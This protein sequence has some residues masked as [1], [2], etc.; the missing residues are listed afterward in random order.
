M[1]DKKNYQ[2]KAHKML[3]E[4]FESISMLDKRA[5]E[6]SG[7]VREGLKDTIE[8]LKRES[9]ELKG[10]FA[11]L[12]EDGSESWSEVRDGFDNAASALNDAF[13]KAWKKFNSKE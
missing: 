7:N 1:T 4:L 8:D 12:S 10:K 11:K 5:Q 6:A 13:F 3:D 9:E 2:E